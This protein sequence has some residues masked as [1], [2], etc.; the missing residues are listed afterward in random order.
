MLFHHDDEQQSIRPQPSCARR[1]TAASR[2]RNASHQTS[3]TGCSTMKYHDT[4]PRRARTLIE[5]AAL[6]VTLVSLM[7]IPSS[8]DDE[9]ER[10]LSGQV[11][12]EHG[13]PLGNVPVTLEEFGFRFRTVTDV[14]GR[15]DF[16]D[17]RPGM[18]EIVINHEGYTPVRRT[19]PADDGQRIQMRIRLQPMALPERSYV[20]TG[21]ST[22]D[23]SQFRENFPKEARRAFD[24]GLR[25]KNRGKV[26]DAV[27]HL[28]E[29]VRIAPDYYDAHLDLGVLYQ[30]EGRLEDAEQHYDIARSLTPNRP[31][32]L[33]NLGTIYLLRDENERAAG[34]LLEAA[35]MTPRPA[36]AFINLGVAYYKL[37]RPDEA[38]AAV[39]RAKELSDSGLIRLLLANIYL[40]KQRPDQGLEQLDAYLEE[41]PSGDSR[42]QVLQMRAKILG[43]K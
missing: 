20:A 40:K 18:H 31:Q 36:D 30:N 41:N 33:I 19:V 15:F 21:D 11:L 2:R 43:Q 3:A 22:I 32:P 13:M 28:E 23:V 27:K 42:E 14:L 9:Q 34:I 39:L 7:T 26:A 25:D 8:A 1:V 29:A 5:H 24:R 17:V 12:T 10:W 38:E 6:I 4:S 35:A 37:G 16:L